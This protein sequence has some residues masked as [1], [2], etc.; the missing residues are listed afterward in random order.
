M[1]LLT[2]EAA[3]DYIRIAIFWM[4]SVHHRLDTWYWFYSKKHHLQRLWNHGKLNGVWLGKSQSLGEHWSFYPSPD[5]CHMCW[6]LICCDVIPQIYQSFQQPSLPY[7][8]G[9]KATQLGGEINLSFFSGFCHVF[10]SLQCK[11]NSCASLDYAMQDKPSV[12]WFL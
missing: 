11:K 9:P 6:F 3:F 1:V 12:I 7:H 8:K 10:R 2:W 4:S 5:S